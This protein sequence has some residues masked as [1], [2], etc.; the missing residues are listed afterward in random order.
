MNDSQTP[1]THVSLKNRATAFAAMAALVAGMAL[2]TPKTAEA[3]GYF[4]VTQ[5]GINLGNHNRSGLKL[6]KTGL[7]LG[8]SSNQIAVQHNKGLGASVSVNPY[9]GKPVFNI[10]YEDMGK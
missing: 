1:K 6:G 2:A 5:N 9:T 4:T 10:Q 8:V 3:E 7:Y